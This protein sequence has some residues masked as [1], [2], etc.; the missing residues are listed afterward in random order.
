MGQY[1]KEQAVSIVVSCAEKYR[2]EL[3][4][5]S[6]LFLCMD[7]HKKIS[8]IEFTFDASNFLHL[9]GLKLHKISPLDFYQRCLD[10]RV[11]VKD[12]D[13]APDGTTPLKLD[14]L[15]YIMNKYL[16]AA[17]IGD[18]NSN[19]PKLYTEKLVGSVK[20]CVGFIE[21]DTERYVPNTVLRVDIREYASNIVQVIAV[22]RKNRFDAVYGEL[23][24]KSKKVDLNTIQFP[25]EYSYLSALNP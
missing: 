19:N 3:S 5:K 15:P 24:Y 11:S 14:V 17:M 23:T 7:K 18:Y 22:Y 9:T 4:G 1:K 21:T 6:L 13:F 25:D 16:S 2:D 20:A 10:H 12:F 8:T